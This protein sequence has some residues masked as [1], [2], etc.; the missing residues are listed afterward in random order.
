MTEP[1]RDECSEIRE[2][3][4]D[5]FDGRT[6]SSAPDRA[7]FAAPRVLCESCRVYRAAVEGISAAFRDPGDEPVPA[8]RIVAAVLREIRPG[9]P[10]G[11]DGRARAGPLRAA[12]GF[13]AALAAAAAVWIAVAGLSVAPG[14]G[15]AAPEP[16]TITAGP[17]SPHARSAER[18]AA[19]RRVQPLADLALE[20]AMNR[21]S[22][23]RR[24]EFILGLSPEI[25]PYDEERTLRTIRRR[26]GDDIILTSGR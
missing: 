16:D 9:S 22:D 6:G 20:Y 2:R 7:Q 5:Y 26:A 4:S 11:R 12:V 24:S 1:G 13:G 19:G 15:A 18:V 14:T 21:A 3:L 8:D 17:A 25:I 23:E 10:A